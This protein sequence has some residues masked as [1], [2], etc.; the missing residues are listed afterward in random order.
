MIYYFNGRIL[1][2]PG[3]NTVKPNTD[4]QLSRSRI[5]LGTGGWRWL[6]ERMRKPLDRGR[7][8]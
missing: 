4:S 3:S 5:D 2:Y 1:L 6:S 8:I 7:C